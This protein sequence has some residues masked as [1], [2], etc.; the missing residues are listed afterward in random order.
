MYAT[1]W[2]GHEHLS[3]GQYRLLSY[4]QLQNVGN[5]TLIWF[6]AIWECAQFCVMNNLK[7]SLGKP[8][9]TFLALEEQTNH[10]STS[11]SSGEVN[12]STDK[13]DWWCDLHRCR[14]LLQLIEA[15]EKRMYHP[16]EAAALSLPQ[17]PK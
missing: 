6:W 1:T 8:Q 10:S 2:L 17:L 11:S 5:N 3:E 16:Y 13:D 7:T 15:L 9:E 14:L 4:E 12:V